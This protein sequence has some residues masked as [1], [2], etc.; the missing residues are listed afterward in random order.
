[1]Q[2]FALLAFVLAGAGFSTTVFAES[3]EEAFIS[4]YTT[5][6][7]LLAERAKLRATDEQLPQAEAN[8]HP[9]V[10]M[11]GDAAR[12][13]SQS[14]ALSYLPD[15]TPY[16]TRTNI[17]YGSQ[18]V[19]MEVTEALYRG[20]RTVAQIK[21]A[22]ASIRAER[23]QLASTEQTVMLQAASAYLD[24]VQN[25]SILESS[26]E[27]EHL[28]QHQVDVTTDRFKNG[29]V[30]RTDVAFTQSRLA[31]G[32]ANRQQAEANLGSARAAYLATVGH[33]PEKLVPPDVNQDLPSSED[34]ALQRAEDDNPTIQ[35]A[36]YTYQAAEHGIDLVAGELQPTVSL[37]G[38]ANKG[39]SY[40]GPG[41]WQRAAEA[42]VNVS[43]PIY[44]QGQEYARLRAQKS[45]TM[46]LRITLDEAK[47]EA[48]EA[49]SQ[50]WQNWQA[51]L[52]RVA[53]FT[54]QV[55]AAR[56]AVEGFEQES[57]LGA[58]SVVDVLNAE[59]ELLSAEI[60]LAQA[61][62]DEGV[63]AFQLRSATG[64]LTAA[65]LALNV[66]I[67]DPVKHYEDVRGRWIGTS[68]P[69]SDEA[70]PR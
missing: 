14:N 48:R 56:V 25:Q 65:S 17:V 61:R 64:R 53:S 10:T 66:E 30:T 9:S 16:T 11:S 39:F 47:R 23:A 22:E 26:I 28:L 67:Y 51:A 4:V 1:M 15:G 36:D 50:A 12:T 38:N 19:A 7:T 58:R 41:S 13:D 33:A 43:V 40:D 69:Q 60:S 6:P 31:A 42:T 29:E 45:T 44:Q 35:S 37:N 5:S 27:N 34:E 8:W 68:V 55:K 63:A 21:Q 70:G 3:L 2:K 18:N 32:H 52:G 57:K 46:Q 49:T 62:H 59:Q 24:V 20:G 54:E